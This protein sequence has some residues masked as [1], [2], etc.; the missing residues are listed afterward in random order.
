MKYI[1]RPVVTVLLIGCATQ[2]IVLVTADHI[3]SEAGPPYDPNIYR[4]YVDNVLQY[5]A[6]QTYFT[7]EFTLHT[8][9]PTR[10]EGS[11]AGNATCDATYIDVCLT[12]LQ[13]GITELDRHCGE[14]NAGEYFTGDCN[15]R[16]WEIS[17]G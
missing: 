9:F 15:I 17:N 1:L 2:L 5:L 4:T 12:C 8:W 6:E 14:Y 10:D 3:C 16:F 13:N 11:V 7:P